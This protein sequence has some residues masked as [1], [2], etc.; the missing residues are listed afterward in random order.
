M[1]CSAGAGKASTK[2]SK[3]SQLTIERVWKTLQ[4]KTYGPKTVLIVYLLSFNLSSVQVLHAWKSNCLPL[5]FWVNFI[6]NPDFIFDVNK[7]VSTNTVH[8]NR[9]FLSIIV[10]DWKVTKAAISCFN[11]RF[12]LDPFPPQHVNF[13]KSILDFCRLIKTNNSIKYKPVGWPT[14]LFS[15]RI[16]WIF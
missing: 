8:L 12:S 2:I 4:L 13:L 14:P 16:S 6:K 11:S 5:R 7:T 10:W 9:F 1:Y 15:L 3:T